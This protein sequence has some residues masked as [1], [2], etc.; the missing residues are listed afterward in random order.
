MSALETLAASPRLLKGRES[1][2]LLYDQPWLAPGRHK[3]RDYASGHA[4]LA[5]SGPG[6]LIRAKH[7]APDTN[8]IVGSML[9]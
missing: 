6:G 7:A 3:R 5:A 8:Q 2:C 9:T 1:A 4:P